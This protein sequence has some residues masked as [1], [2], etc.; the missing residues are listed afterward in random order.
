MKL[1]QGKIFLLPVMAAALVACG[2]GSDS[3]PP[4]ETIT[5]TGTVAKGIVSGAKM[6]VLSA[7]A[8]PVVL[9][10]GFTTDAN[11]RYTIK[12]N[13]TS[14]PVVIEADLEGA[15]IADETNP[16]VPYEG[17]SGEKMRAIISPTAA[18]ATANVTPFSEMAVD[19]VAE[20]G[21]EAKAVN[22]ANRIVRQLLNNT[23]HLTASPT[24]GA[25]LAKLTAVQ[26]LVNS[27][28]G[29]LAS[30]LTQLRDAAD[31]GRDESVSIDPAQVDEL[32]AA[33]GE[34]P[35]CAGAFTKPDPIKIGTGDLV[36][37]VYSLFQDLR[38][39]L[40]AYS[41]ET[42]TGELDVAAVKLD[43]AVKAAV[44]PID[45]EMLGVLAM[46]SKG[47]RA[48]R[49]VK[50]GAL[51]QQFINSGASYGRTATFRTDGTPVV[52]GPLPRYGCEVARATVETK[53]DGSQDVQSDYTTSGVTA[54]N[55]NVFACFGVG[56]AGRLYPARYGDTS[57]WHSVLFIPQT[58]GSVKYV[59]QLRSR[60]FDQRLGAATR[61]K[62]V[63]GNLGVT[64]D[65]SSELT[66]FRLN[67]KLVPGLQ[68]HAP[69]EY[70][71]LDRVDA[72]LSFA[73]SAPTATSGKYD[74]S[75]LMTLY[76][77]DNVFASSVEIASGS[78]VEVK[79]DVPF[80]YTDYIYGGESCPAGFSAA[81]GSVAPTLS[82]VGTVTGIEE[83]FSALNLDVTVTAP[84]VKFQGIVSAGTP[85]F[86]STQ[87]EYIPTKVSLQGKIFEADG[88]GFRLLLDG[89]GSVELLNYASFD[90]TGN[91]AAPVKVGFDGKVLLK[92]RPE[93][94]LTLS[95]ERTEQR[96][97]SLS[98]TFFWNS[99]ALKF[100]AATNG[101]WTISNDAG[102]RFTI[103]E[104]ESDVAQD[105]FL[106]DA[107]VGTVNFGQSRI[108][109]SDGRFQQF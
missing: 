37:P 73:G 53:A 68:G 89:A 101:D 104:G 11:G 102:V 72:T 64:R 39:T 9:A 6:R 5:L 107:K 50:S 13:K 105:V 35:A 75:G 99:K 24:E 15:I 63:Y 91:T 28:E 40:L 43:E 109:Y 82:C 70:A 25:L 88:T 76:K 71:T 106:G 33:C 100:A 85:S 95:G 16:D 84:G 103:P 61:V 2:G 67:G 54:S 57:Y 23:D 87:T 10:S 46:F 26:Q 21:W 30:V 3:P 62:A 12:L 83:G 98:G 41:N 55:A 74:L 56:T 86:D 42:Q 65:S 19:L 78:M 58:D 97:Q 49:D 45:D 96:A 81:F 36:D 90:A 18:T 14:G 59:H 47:D 52:A 31:G 38:D 4:P 66:G 80:S 51:T 94:R 7:A 92:N 20:A 22:D 32:E 69:G 27:T 93:M 79:T 8:S 1:V 34:A 77:K 29:G 17:K 44:Q 108:D 48:Y 60:P